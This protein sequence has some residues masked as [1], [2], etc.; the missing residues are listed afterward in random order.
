MMAQEPTQLV[1]IEY[2]IRGALGL[3]LF[4]TAMPGLAVQV[5]LDSDQGDLALLVEVLYTDEGPAF[6]SV[7]EAGM[8]DKFEAEELAKVVLKK[9]GEVSPFYGRVDVRKWEDALMKGAEHPSN[10][11]ISIAM[12]E[13]SDLMVIGEELHRT[14]RPDRYYGIP[15][16]RLADCQRMAF[17]AA[18]K[19]INGIAKKD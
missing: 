8:L 9:L 14:F 17:S 7:E 13:C 18:C 2:N 6:S 11:G 15:V 1:P 3:R 12:W 19:V 10:M 5:A 4:I 16:S